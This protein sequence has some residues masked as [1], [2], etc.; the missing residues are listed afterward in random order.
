MA[1]GPRALAFGAAILAGACWGVSFLAP[2]ILMDTNPSTVALF[3]FLFFGASA[4][5]AL[6]LRRKHLPAITWKTTEVAI[7]LALLG[8]SLYYYLLAVAVRDAGMVFSTAIIG[9]LPLTILLVS[10]SWRKGLRLW[11]PIL[12]ILTGAILI[13]F[14]LFGGAY[15]EYLQRTELERG[16]GLASAL[17]ALVLW[18]AFAT[19]NARFLRRHAEWSPMDWAGVLGIA[20]AISAGVIFYGIEGSNWQAEFAR[21]A[22]SPK[23]LLWTGFMGIAGAWLATGLWNYASRALPPATLGMLLIFESVF[24]LL[25]GFI[26]DERIPTVRESCA[27]LLLL[28]GA[29]VGLARLTNNKSSNELREGADGRR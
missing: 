17:G 3:R 27:I 6:F 14:E 26:Y 15:S 10:V 4:L 7:G 12:C 23:V 13:P 29:V 11:F 24:G 18:T 1:L 8:Y 2:R 25:F 22:A 21:A 20:A 9:L 16:I 19:M 5:I 28:G